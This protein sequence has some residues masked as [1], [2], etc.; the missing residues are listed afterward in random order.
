LLGGGAADDLPAAGLAGARLLDGTF[1]FDASGVTSR[2][3]FSDSVV[4]NCTISLVCSER[5]FLKKNQRNL[6]LF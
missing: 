3:V 4:A 2:L 5:K 6:V 1:K